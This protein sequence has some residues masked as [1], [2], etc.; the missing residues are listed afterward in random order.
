MSRE[1]MQ[2]LEMVKAAYSQATPPPEGRTPCAPTGGGVVRRMWCEGCGC[3]TVHRLE[4]R[5]DWDYFGCGEC[6]VYGH[7]YRVR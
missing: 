3:E 5:G 1:S 6:Q 2:F 7:W 4:V